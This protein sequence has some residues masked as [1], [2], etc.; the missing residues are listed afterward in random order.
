M[1]DRTF[2]ASAR[3]LRRALS[4]GALG[5]LLTGAAVEALA[6][7]TCMVASGATLSFGAIVALASTGDVTTNSGTSFW[8]NCT[9]EVSAAPAPLCV[10]ANAHVGRQFPSFCVERDVRRRRGRF[11]CIT[12]DCPCA[13]SLRRC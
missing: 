12:G 13:N 5:F 2:Y 10:A 3:S 1:S 4:R 6:I 9:A 8:V 7:P 11:R